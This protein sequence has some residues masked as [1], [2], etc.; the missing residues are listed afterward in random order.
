MRSVKALPET[1][2]ELLWWALH[3]LRQSG[4]TIRGVIRHPYALRIIISQHNTAE[5]MRSEVLLYFNKALQPTE[6]E[7]TG[8]DSRMVRT[9][10]ACLR[11]ALRPKP[12]FIFPVTQ[13]SLTMAPPAQ[14]S[15]LV[16]STPQFPIA[17]SSLQAS[18]EALE[19]LAQFNRYVHR[20]LVAPS[21]PFPATETLELPVPVHAF[22][23]E[24]ETVL[25]EQL[26]QSPEFWELPPAHLSVLLRSLRRLHPANIAVA[27]GELLE[28]GLRLHLLR[29]G[30]EGTIVNYF[31]RNG[32]PGRVVT[33]GPCRPLAAEA[34][35]IL[36][37]PLLGKEQEFP[38]NTPLG[39]LS[40]F[41]HLA[42][43]AS[44]CQVEIRYAA[45]HAGTLRMWLADAH[46]D[47]LELTLLSGPGDE[48][49]RVQEVRYQSA[50][51]MTAL[52]TALESLYCVDAQ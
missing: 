28:N 43:W 1:L 25:A 26:A 47:W 3:F 45:L 39:L 31:K 35:Q 9:A 19:Q 18:E 36:N 4:I 17:Y 32:E 14:D 29:D 41:Y 42:D 16:P 7:P 48:L 51:M 22:S 30:Q 38:R 46:F 52:Q 11:A 40:V 8:P 34:V 33:E 44:R 5:E 12:V 10:V 37:V 2:R 6:A 50:A 15:N 23:P 49:L 27:P 24:Q 13:A 20:C 21:G